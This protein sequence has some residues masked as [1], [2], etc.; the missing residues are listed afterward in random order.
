M[1]M[2]HAEVLKVLPLLAPQ[3]IAATA[4]GSSYI[5]LNQCVGLVEFEVNFGALTATDST[6]GVVITI[7]GSTAGASSD[8]NTAIAFQYALSSA[9]NTDSM[10]AITAATAAGVTLTSGSNDNMTLLCYVDPAVLTAGVTDGRWARVYLT[11]TSDQT[12]SLVSVVARY[13]PRY[14]QAS[15]PSST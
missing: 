4:T 14:A 8:T 1:K 2:A 6:D 13:T 12:V 5:D 3:D 10:G 7:E 15:I 9:V 11:P